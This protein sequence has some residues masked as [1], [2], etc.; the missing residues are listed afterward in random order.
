MHYRDHFLCH[1]IFYKF[2]LRPTIKVQLL[3]GH[4]HYGSQGIAKG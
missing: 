2:G 1:F 3:N 4:K